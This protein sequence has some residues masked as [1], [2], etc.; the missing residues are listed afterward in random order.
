[1]SPEGAPAV[2]QLRAVYDFKFRCVNFDQ[3]PEW[4]EYPSG[5]RYEGALQGDIYKEAFGPEVHLIGPR[6]GVFW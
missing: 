6:K 2:H 3:Q 1:V 4:R 5:H